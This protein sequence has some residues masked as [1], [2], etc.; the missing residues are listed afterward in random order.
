[1]RVTTDIGYLLNKATRQFRLQLGDSLAGMGLTPQQAA[2]LM[3]IARSD[4]GRLTPRSIAEAIDTDAATTSGLLDRLTRD[5]WLDAVPNP[6]DGRSRLIGL[7]TKAEAAIPSVMVAAEAVSGQAT[8]HLTTT[9][10]EILSRLLA[11]LCET[12]RTPAAKRKAGSR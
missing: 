10:R 4:A 7:T 6:D 8:A 1:V 12:E 3:A 5:G 9:E 11:K 2:V